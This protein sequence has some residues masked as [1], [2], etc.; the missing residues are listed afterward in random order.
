MLTKKIM[1][2]YFASSLLLGM[3]FAVWRMALMFR[4]YDPYNNEYSTDAKTSLQVFGYVLCFSLLAMATS[5]FFLRK[6]TFSE[7]SASS[8]QLSVFSSAL[9]GFVF[10][11]IGFLVLLYYAKELFSADT[12]PFFKGMRIVSFVLLFLSAIYFIL[13]AA[14][15]RISLKAKKSCSFFPTLFALSLLIVSYINPAYNYTDPNHN[16]C[17]IS[18][19][20]LLLFFLYETRSTVTGNSTPIR[21]VFSLV[22]LICLLAYILPICILMAFWELSTGIDVLFEA[23]ECGALFYIV[24]V[25]YSMI[26]AVKPKTITAKS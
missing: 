10:V 3:G 19:C 8:N 23:V 25:L 4:Y 2:A 16:L 11:A 26:H 15:S 7:F 12:T 1:S 9:L 5:Y 13:S 22:A 20:A 18:I 24:A 21:F 14:A 17:N 6:H